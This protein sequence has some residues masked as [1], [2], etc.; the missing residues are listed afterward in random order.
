MVDVRHVRCFQTQMYSK[1]LRTLFLTNVKR[2]CARRVKKT[3][4]IAYK[5]YKM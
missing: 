5:T 3:A 2:G 4:Y 1:N